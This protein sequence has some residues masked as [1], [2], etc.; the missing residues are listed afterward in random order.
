MKNEAEAHYLCALLNSKPVREFV[1]TYS[2]AGRGFGAPSVM[3]HIGIPK[4]NPKDSLH[5]QLANL[6]KKLHEYNGA[7]KNLSGLEAQVDSLV[8]KLFSISQ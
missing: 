8:K 5:T 7:E 2:S 4:F 6:S 3:N 1:K